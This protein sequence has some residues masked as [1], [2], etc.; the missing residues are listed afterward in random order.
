MGILATLKSLGLSCKAPSYI[1]YNI[2]SREFEW[3]D[4]YRDS[5]NL[6]Y[7][8]KFPIIYFSSSKFL[9]YSIIG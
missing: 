7:K 2:N 4:K 5:R 9:E 3:Q 8:Y 1:T 6:L